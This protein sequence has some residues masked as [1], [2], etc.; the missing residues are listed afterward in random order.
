[1]K[2]IDDG[3]SKY[4]QS[5]SIMWLCIRHTSIHPQ[6][7]RQNRSVGAI[8]NSVTQLNTNIPGAESS[9]TV[10]ISGLLMLAFKDPD[11]T[12]CAQHYCGTLQE[13]CPAINRKCPGML[14][15]GVIMYDAHPR[16]AHPVQV[17]CAA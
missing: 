17:H 11:I 8:G 13:L 7:V 6:A 9:Q 3:M 16:L 1:M 14:M 15:R 2:P 10:H 12:V 4:G 5:E